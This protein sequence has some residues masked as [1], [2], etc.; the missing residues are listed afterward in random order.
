[1]LISVCFILREILNG[2]LGLCTYLPLTCCIRDQK[3]YS[4]SLPCSMSVIDGKTHVA[5][6]HPS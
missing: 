3:C 6:Y 2:S 1:M 5:S 4:L